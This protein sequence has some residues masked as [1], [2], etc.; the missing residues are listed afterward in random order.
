MDHTTPEQPAP[1]TPPLQI[2]QKAP[3]AQTP[4]RTTRF[5]SSLQSAMSAIGI[6]R[7]PADQ[8]HPPSVPPPPTTNAT[9]TLPKRRGRP[10]KTA[11]LTPAV[12]KPVPIPQ[13][14][15]SAKATSSPPAAVGHGTT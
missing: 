2:E 5:H 3:V 15:A 4:P 10:K 14:P 11:Q 8:A 12:P 1:V 9:G 13:T 6:L 7:P